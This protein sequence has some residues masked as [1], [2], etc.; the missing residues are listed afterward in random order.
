MAAL[1]AGWRAQIMVVRARQQLSKQ[2]ECRRHVI[3]RSQ[4]ARLRC[5]LELH[6]PQTMFVK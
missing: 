1:L 6:D 3:T 5:R 4:P 2:I